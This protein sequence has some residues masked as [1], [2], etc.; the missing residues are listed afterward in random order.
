LTLV[1]LLLLK[2]AFQHIK[3]ANIEVML[4]QLPHKAA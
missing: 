2:F 4:Y 3:Y 1:K